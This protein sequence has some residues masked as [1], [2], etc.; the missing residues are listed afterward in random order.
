MSSESWC[1]KFITWAGLGNST[2]CHQACTIKTKKEICITFFSRMI[3]ICE[4]PMQASHSF[5]ENIQ[6][7]RE[8]TTIRSF[9]VKFLLWAMLARASLLHLFHQILL[10]EILLCSLISASLD[11]T[12]YHVSGFKKSFSRFNFANTNYLGSS[13]GESAKRPWPFHPSDS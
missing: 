5:Q 3:L 1:Y 2:R 7:G 10:I 6:V 4:I 12:R 11:L 9:H 13:A 8:I